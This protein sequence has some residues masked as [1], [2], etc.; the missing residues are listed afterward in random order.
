MDGI[1]VRHEAQVPGGQ[2]YRILGIGKA[3]APPA[4][5]PEA[6]G[7]MEVMTG[8]PLPIGA[9][10]VI[11]VEEIEVRD[12][13]AI[14]LAPESI[15]RGR[16]IQAKGTDSPGGR[17]LVPSGVRLQASHIAVA[18][19]VGMDAIRVVRRPLVRVVSTGDEIIGA[20]LRPQP[21]QIRGSNPQALAAMVA[22]WADCEY[23]RAADTPEALDEVLAWGLSGA[24]M[25]VL[26]GGVS[27]GKFD[28]V[29]E[30]LG[31]NGVARL[32]H[33]AAIKPGKPIWFGRGPVDMPVFGLPGNPVSFMICFRRFAFPLLR[34]MAGHA[35]WEVPERVRLSEPVMGKPGLA[36]FQPVSLDPLNGPERSVSPCA[37]NGS[38]DFCGLAGSDGF[39]EIGSGAD[40]IPA[41]AS[42]PFYPW[43]M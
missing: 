41:G 33:K 16:N 24:D 11:P 30:A 43:G 3:G 34:A 13:R 4:L 26:S 37:I 31:R 15:R 19:S 42:V 9:D 8:A 25:L 12:G 21:W 6:G 23:R 32:F 7:C 2:G 27:A 39:V 14:P 1:A 17:A 18:A 22:G 35:G 40:P 10:T 20:G 28:L 29:P 5:L 36:L 38:G